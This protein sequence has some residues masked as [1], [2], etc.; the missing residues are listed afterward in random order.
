MIRFPRGVFTQYV[1]TR[2]LAIVVA[3]LAPLW[4]FTLVPRAAIIPLIG[5]AVVIVLVGVDALLIPPRRKIDLVRIL[6]QLV[7]VGDSVH[8]EYRLQNQTTRTLSVIVYDAFPQA[9]AAHVFPRTLR[10]APHTSATAR[11]GVTGKFRGEHD[12]GVVVV[13]L[14]GPLDLVRRSL[15]Y[16]LDDRITVIPS[17]AG[18]KGYHLQAAQ[19]RMR[20]AGSRAL[21]MRGASATFAGLRDY[22]PGDD[23]RYVDWKATARR[24]RM[25]SK[26]FAVEQGQTIVIAV[27]AGRMMTQFA[28]DRPRFEYALSS[29]L[30][31]A[32][33]ALASG[34]RVGLLVFNDV[35]RSYVTPGRGAT[36]RHDIR[37]ALIT[38]SATLAE[39]DYA[40]AFR[41][42]AARQRRRSM[43]V[44]FTDVVD[45][46]S[47]GA[48]I[49]HTVRTAQRH[50]PL[51]VA[52]R[53]A[54]LTEAAIPSPNASLDTTYDAAAAE[55]LLLSRA[56]ALERMRQRGVA[57][58]DTPP[59]S[60]TAAVINRY[61]E[62]KDR[63][64][65]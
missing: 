29:A 42:L 39:P 35:V 60:M 47:S 18:A 48:M 27:D 65:L 58:L 59:L 16:T 17:I 37:S 23:P 12:L 52:L 40:A 61:L 19:Y 49:A 64:A 38:A 13:R 20:L 55:E 41:T 33:V 44:L 2:R 56:D 32:D 24:E 1:P 63:S 7:G 62:L 15:R 30:L 26:E 8:G 50:V 14:S 11:I 28:G 3:V 4:L 45:P 53:N 34:D 43:I 22:T 36:V 5:V 31:L 51:V 25:T 9:V 10:I 46:R 57:V 21:R 6:P 54:Q